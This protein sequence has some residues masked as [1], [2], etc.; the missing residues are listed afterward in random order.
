M[1]NVLSSRGI[2]NTLDLN[3]GVLAVLFCVTLVV[4]VPGCGE[5]GGGAKEYALQGE[6]VDAG[7]PFSKIKYVSG[8]VSLNDRCAVDRER[9]ERRVPPVYVNGQPVG[10]C[11]VRCAN[12]F[13][14]EPEKYLR[15]LNIRIKC[16]IDR[17]KDA[18]LSA[19]SRAFVNYEV[20]YFSSPARLR[21]FIAAPHRY[22]GE[23]TDPISTERFQPSEGSPRRNRGGRA[24][25]FNSEDNANAFDAKTTEFH[26]PTVEMK[27]L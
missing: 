18:L 9:L 24:F 20:Y 12:M 4:Y 17:E 8:L 3:K 14:V 7:A 15:S 10:F 26:P 21:D 19:G 2:N 5:K 13:L 6:Y 22:S 23:I 16:A 27:E 25:F 1:G 11:S